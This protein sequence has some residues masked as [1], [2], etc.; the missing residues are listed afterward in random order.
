MKDML[1][2][3]REK[4]VPE[5]LKKFNYTSIMQVPKIDKISLNI[6]V[7][8]SIV[9]KKKLDCAISDLTLIS[10]QKACI[11]RAKKSIAGFKIRK[12]Y[13]IGC[14]VTLRGL[15]KWHFFNKLINIVIPRIRDFRGFSRNSFDGFGNYNF[16]IKEQI[17]FPE[18]DYEKIDNIRGFNITIVT[19]ANSNEEALFLL[20]KFNF[21]F[22]K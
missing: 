11:T 5:F 6:G 1:S 18:I 20:S 17:I 8:D 14:K 15:R 9:N 3:Y 22:R 4:I 10:G 19:T 21:P 16:G 12:G 2:F 7:G 13:S